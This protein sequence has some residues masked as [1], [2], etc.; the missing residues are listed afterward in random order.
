M[1]RGDSRQF[2][3]LFDEP[4]RAGA[5]VPATRQVVRERG[6]GSRAAIEQELADTH[7]QLQSNIDDLAASNEELQSANEEILSS[8]E[9]LQ[10]T[11]EELD[12]AKE[13][14]QSTN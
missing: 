7:H 6:G 13:E 8:N 2:L 5:R 11:N 10:S 1:G 9:E 14:M 12:T 4:A 3:V